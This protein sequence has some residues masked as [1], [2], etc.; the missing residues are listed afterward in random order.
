MAQNRIQDINSK[1]CGGVSIK[2][3]LNK[4]LQKLSK[5]PKN[6]PQKTKCPT[7]TSIFSKKVAF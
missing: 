7:T 4:L 5:I 2:T 6:I 3:I 1:G